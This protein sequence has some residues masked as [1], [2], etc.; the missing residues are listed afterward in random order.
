M[1]GHVVDG[2]GG[3]I[4][5]TAAALAQVVVHAAESVSGARIRRP[6]RGL[7]IGVAEG[8]ARV[9]IDLAVGFGGVVPDVAG[10]VQARVAEALRS[11]C[12]LSVDAVDVS[13]E[14]LDG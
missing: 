14:E 4:E 6:R 1:T 10:E 7:E 8:R 3:K 9:E 11:M 5:I 2:A 13:V 12:G